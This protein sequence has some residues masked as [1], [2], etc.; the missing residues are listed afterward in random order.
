MTVIKKIAGFLITLFL[1]SLITFF[2]FNIIPGNPAVAI[3]GPDAASS[4]IEKL[5]QELG[6]NKPL[7]NRYISW[8]ANAITGDFGISYKYNQPVSSIILGALKI[9]LN[10]SVFTIFLALIIGIPFGIFFAKMSQNP[11]A[12]GLEVFSQIWFSTPSFCTAIFLIMVFT[13]KFNLFPSMGYVDWKVSP[14]LCIKSLFLPA[15]SLALG[16]GAIMARYVKTE[17]TIQQ[18]MNYVRTAK[19]KGLSPLNIDLHHI[20]R[21]SL[22]PII[23]MLGLMITEVLGGSLIV[24]N[25]FSLPGVG[26]LIATSISSRDFPL[27]QGLVLYLA[28]I[29]TLC[30]LLIDILYYVIDPTLSITKKRHFKGK[31]KAE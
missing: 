23:T 12:K 6:L 5:E 27:I 25:V 22:F 19:S 26:R 18:E 28:F 16:S 9:T 15:L 20:L 7:L 13:V 24:E 17:F 10:L 4:Q 14:I 31:Q 11:F 21:N 1:V 29:T 2:I 3:L 8:L 30:N